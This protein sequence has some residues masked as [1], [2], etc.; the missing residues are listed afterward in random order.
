MKNQRNL[1]CNAGDG[2]L[3]RKTPQRNRKASLLLRFE[4]RPFLQA[5]NPLCLWIKS[6]KDREEW[7]KI[8]GIGKKTIEVRFSNLFIHFDH[9]ADDSIGVPLTHDSCLIPSFVVQDAELSGRVHVPRKVEESVESLLMDLMHHEQQEVERL[10]KKKK[11]IILREEEEEVQQPKRTLSALDRLNQY[12]M[13]QI[14]L[15]EPEMVLLAAIKDGEEPG[16]RIQEGCVGSTL[17]ASLL[18]FLATMWGCFCKK[19]KKKLVSA[20]PVIEQHELEPLN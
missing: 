8:I 3:E 17:F 7:C 6:G 5:S 18:G 10:L 4:R 20:E 9:F 12:H 2:P 14:T 15:P 19:R 11:E 16:T 1:D 13:F